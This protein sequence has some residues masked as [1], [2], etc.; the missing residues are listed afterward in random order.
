MRKREFVLSDAEIKKF[1]NAEQS[2]RDAY[3]LKRL[4]AVRLYGSG[5]LISRIQEMVNAAENTIRQWVMRYQARGVSGLASQWQG[6]NANK[7]TD[8]QRADLMQRIDSYTPDQLIAPD[9]RTDEGIFWTI[10]DFQIV[11]EQWYG[12]VYKSENSY[13]NLMRACDLSYQK[14]EKVFRSQPSAEQLA[15]FEAQLEKK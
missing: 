4:Q 8:E 10:S 15:E 13:Y 3:E 1:R 11:I 12:V 5:E 14:A 7:L 2:T 9:V 6:G